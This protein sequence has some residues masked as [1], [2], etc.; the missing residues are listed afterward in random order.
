M[1]A[2]AGLATV[3][4][5]SGYGAEQ[6]QGPLR[7]ALARALPRRSPPRALRERVGDY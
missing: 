7:E 1:Q 2:A 3:E 4:G 5:Y 6:G